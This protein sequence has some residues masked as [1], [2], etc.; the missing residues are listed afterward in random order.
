MTT[1]LE[2]SYL[3][4]TIFSETV[5]IDKLHYFHGGICLPWKYE[6]DNFSGIT[7]MFATRKKSFVENL[8]ITDSK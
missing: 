7:A 4:A 3:F 5:W 8:N 2:N 6:K 1:F